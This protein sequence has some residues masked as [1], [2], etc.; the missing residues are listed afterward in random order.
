MN[1]WTWQQCTQAAIS[2]M[3][4][5]GFNHIKNERTLRNL[6]MTYRVNE[7]VPVPFSV[8]TRQPFI[9]L[10]MPELKHKIVLFCNKQVADGTLSTDCLQT[11]LKK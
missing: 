6:N 2:V 8:S 11:E 1:T 3:N 10:I 7:K 9:F 5:A 4:D